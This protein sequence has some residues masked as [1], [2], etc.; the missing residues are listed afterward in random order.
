[1]E[2]LFK[3]IEEKIDTYTTSL[4]TSPVKTIIKTAFVIFILF[5]IVKYGKK[6]FKSI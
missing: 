5:T 1:M 3:T 2:Q 4:S 6:F